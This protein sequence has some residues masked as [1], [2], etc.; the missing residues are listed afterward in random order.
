MAAGWFLS[1]FRDPVGEEIFVLF[2]RILDLSSDSEL[3]S[4]FAFHWAR[5]ANEQLFL[6]SKGETVFTA[7]DRKRDGEKNGLGKG[8]AVAY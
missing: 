2:F 1:E 8:L 3:G 4:C 6:Q 7:G 5:C